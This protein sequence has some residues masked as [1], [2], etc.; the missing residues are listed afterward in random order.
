VSA[1]H[2]RHVHIYFPSTLKSEEKPQ[3]PK[4]AA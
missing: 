2:A 3:P 1:N 4:I